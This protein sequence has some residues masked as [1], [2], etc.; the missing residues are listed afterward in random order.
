[1]TTLAGQNGNG[2]L[3]LVGIGRRQ[4]LRSPWDVIVHGRGLYVAGAGTHQIWRFDL[5][6]DE[7]HPYAGTGAEELYD[8]PRES[9]ALA[10]PSG[11]TREDNRLFVAD[12]ESSA[13]RLVELPPGKEVQT[14][15]GTGLFDFGD[16]DGTGDDARLQHNQGLTWFD[17]WIYV[18]DTYN[19]KIKQINPRT[20]EC[21]TFVGT[22][23][24]GYV[25]GD[26]PQFYEPNG[27][28]ACD[29]KLYVADTNNHAIRVI[30]VKKKTVGT[31]RIDGLQPV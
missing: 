31:L 16:Q 2:I 25:D 13:I 12:A 27:I 1:V 29:G 3:R 20:R 7:L 11:L 15:V 6:T 9:A 28:T 14:I 24:P 17:D 10:Q 19:H 4:A 26:E 18:A 22:G 5:A 23:S 8:A 21:S 30:D